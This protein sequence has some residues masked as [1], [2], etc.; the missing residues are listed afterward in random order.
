M[1]M[2]WLAHL[3]SHSPLNS[4]QGWITLLVWIPPADYILWL[5]FQNHELEKAVCVIKCEGKLI[6]QWLGK[7]LERDS[8][9]EGSDGWL[10]I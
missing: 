8:A 7:N 10:E 3:A 5:M 1:C 2:G 4:I 9:L 6:I